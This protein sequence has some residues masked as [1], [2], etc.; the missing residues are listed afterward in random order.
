MLAS[1]G[2][3]RVWFDPRCG[4]LLTLR[5]LRQSFSVLRSGGLE[6]QND[7]GVK[8]LW[9][10]VGSVGPDNGPEFL[11]KADT[12]EVL[13][14][15]QRLEDT[16]PAPTPKSTSPPAPSSKVRRRRW[17]PTTS[18]AVTCTNSATIPMLGSGGMRS[19]GCP[20][21]GRRQPSSNSAR[22]RSAHFRTS[23]KNAGLSGTHPLEVPLGVGL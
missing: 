3:G 10:D 19:R 13:G 1:V 6:A 23:R 22:W 17:S 7:P 2:S 14:I 20:S 9:R 21:R 5:K 12:S 16:A 8:H 4:P 11:V 15:R 18:T